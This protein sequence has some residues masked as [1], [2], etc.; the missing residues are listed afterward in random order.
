M[1][2]QKIAEV[3]FEITIS[4]YTYEIAFTL[5]NVKKDNFN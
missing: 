4:R 3:G 5:R 2:N 1:N